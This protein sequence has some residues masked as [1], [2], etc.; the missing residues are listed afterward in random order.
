M[1]AASG[2]GSSATG[3]SAAQGLIATLLDNA[4][5]DSF[6]AL[7]LSRTAAATRSDVRSAFRKRALLCHPDKCADVRAAAAFRVLADALEACEADPESERARLA[8][9]P[10]KRAAKRQRTAGGGSGPPAERTWEAWE[11]DLRA[12]EELERCFK[13]AQSARYAGRGAARTLRKVERVAY[14]LDE[15]AGLAPHP[16]LPADPWAPAEAEALDESAAASGVPAPERLLTLLVHL[17]NAHDYCFYCG[18]RF[19][20]FDDLVANCPGVLEE[21][22]END[23]A[24]GGTGEYDY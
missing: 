1:D 5:V 17:R 14:E 21:A 13:S 11:R 10:G 2:A 7:G 9:S 3:S 15:K 16:L 20:D 12:R 19:E 22:H 6:A 24:G 8:A 23:D 18:S 4:N